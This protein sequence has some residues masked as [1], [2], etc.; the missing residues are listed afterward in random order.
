MRR[1]RNAMDKNISCSVKLLYETGPL[2]ISWARKAYMEQ[3][4]ETKVSIYSTKYWAPVEWNTEDAPCQYKRTCI[5]TFPDAIF[6]THWT[7]IWWKN[8]ELEPD[9][10]FREQAPQLV[11]QRQRDPCQ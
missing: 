8:G 1:Q 4:P 9:N 10:C 3:H 5:E 6:A 2:A 7:G 11:R